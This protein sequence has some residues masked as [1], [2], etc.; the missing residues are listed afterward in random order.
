VEEKDLAW[1]L[2]DHPDWFTSTSFITVCKDGGLV[3]FQCMLA[4][5]KPMYTHQPGVHVKYVYPD[6]KIVHFSHKFETKNLELSDGNTSITISGFKVK[7][8]ADKNS[9]HVNFDEKECKQIRGEL[10]FNG[11]GID[12]VKFGDDGKVGFVADK[13]EFESLFFT[14]PRAAVTGKIVVDGKDVNIDGYGF[15]SHFCQNMK[16]HRVALRWQL[17]KFHSTEMTINQNLLITPKQYGKVRVSNGMLVYKGKL[18]AVT[19]ENDIVYPKTQYDKETGYDVPVQAEYSWKG[20][21]LDGRPFSATISVPPTKL[22]D[23]VDILGH[24]PWA[25]RMIIKAFIARP[26]HYQWKDEVTAKVVIGSESFDVKGMALHE[27]T[28]VN[29]E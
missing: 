10:H 9:Y 3:F 20:K 17:M 7:R 8:L 26:F 15:C 1:K 25:I 28:F 23:R 5:L 16:A 14:I 24:L 12:S 11:E 19:M 4:N 2:D 21:T 13:S 6:G 22:V 29:P 18:T 27:V